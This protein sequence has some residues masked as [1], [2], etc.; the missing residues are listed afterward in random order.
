M[1]DLKIEELNFQLGQVSTQLEMAR[2][3]AEE[4]QQQLVGSRAEVCGVAVPVGESVKRCC[5][6]LCLTMPAAVVFYRTAW[7]CLLPA[8]A[9]CMA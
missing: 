6:V 8:S 3:D 5:H 4:L 7:Y 9:W 2:K 1:K